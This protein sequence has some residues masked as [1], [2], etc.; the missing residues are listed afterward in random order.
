MDNYSVN[1]IARLLSTNPETVRRW[2]RSG[3]LEAIQNSKKEGNIITKEMLENFLKKTPKYS[4][5]ALAAAVP[6]FGALPTAAA[7]LTGAAMKQKSNENFSVSPAELKN[8][9]QM[10]LKTSKEAIAGKQQTIRA[11]QAEI[12]AE[13]R[14]V[15]KLERLL[16]AIE[17]QD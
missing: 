6:T 9:I 12:D 13:T 16:S 10:S 4:G 14:N 17:E 2:I 7:M 15:E 1:D 11:L 8:M 5:I 3:K